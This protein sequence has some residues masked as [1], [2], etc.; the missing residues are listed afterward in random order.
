MVEFQED[1]Q[2]NLISNMSPEER[3]KQ[4]EFIFS[5]ELSK[6]SKRQQ[7]KFLKEKGNAER[8]SIEHFNKEFS[9]LRTDIPQVE[10]ESP[11]SPSPSDE[12][13]GSTSTSTQ[14]SSKTI[15]EKEITPQN[16]Y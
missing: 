14:P 11:P 2:Q 12:L 4:K 5:E 6:K 7:N 10:G 8:I 15:S 16:T 9:K 3:E 1:L 13:E